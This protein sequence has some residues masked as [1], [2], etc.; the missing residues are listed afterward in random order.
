[1]LDPTLTGEREVAKI[2]AFFPILPMLGNRWAASRPWEGLTIG[3]NLH[4]TTLTA[5]LVRE[6]MLGGGKWVIS[7]ANPGTTHAHAVATLRNLGVDVYTGGELGDR[8]AR[9]LEHR[10]SILADV[11]F[12]L[13]G[14][15]LDSGDPSRITGA[16][17]ITRSGVQALRRRSGVPFPVVNI[18]DGRLKNAVENRHGVGEGIWRAVGTLTGMHLAGR[19][20]LVIGYGPVGRGLANYARAAGMSVEVVESDPVRRL[21]AHYDG[22]P[23]DELESAI[24]RA[25]IVVTATGAAHVLTAAHLARAQDGVLLLNAGHGGDEID[26]VSLKEAATR[27]DHVAEQVVRYA[28]ADGPRVTLLG[29]GNPLNIVTN[30]GS[31]EPVLLHFAVLGLTLEWIARFGGLGPGEQL[32]PEEIETRAAILALE[33]LQPGRG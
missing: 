15:V 17:E 14:K 24:G 1:M 21:F 8:H 20:L 32:V 19:R 10:P 31:P 11:G 28:L 26:L 2:N 18:N 4:L 23:T 7:A 27:V 16:I 5:A 25:G 29:D 22:Y 33:A 30:S 13:I 6:L 3:L 12:D 9:V